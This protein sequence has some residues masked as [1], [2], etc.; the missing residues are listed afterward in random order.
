M[1]FFEHDKQIVEVL[2]VLILNQ[3]FAVNHGDP[4][5]PLGAF[6]RIPFDDFF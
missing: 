5:D 4:V 1:N 2:L 3:R 6:Q